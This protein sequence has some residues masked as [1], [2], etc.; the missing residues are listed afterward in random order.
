MWS[1]DG[2]V[3]L[4]TLA[5]GRCALKVVEQCTHYE[6]CLNTSCRLVDMNCRDISK[7]VHVCSHPLLPLMCIRVL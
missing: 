4:F 1:D 7:V 5:H 3:C 2:F 6:G